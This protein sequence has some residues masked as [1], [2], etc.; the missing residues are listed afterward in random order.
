MGTYVPQ[1]DSDVFVS[2]SWAD[3][4][5]VLGIDVGWVSHIVDTLEI[6]LAQELGRD[7]IFKV[8]MDKRVRGQRHTGDILNAAKHTATMLLIFSPGYLASDWCRLER[9]CFFDSLDGN[10]HENLR[11]VFVVEKRRRR[12]IPLPPEL[13]G[14]ITYNFWYKDKNNKIRTYG[15]PTFQ[16]QQTEYYY[17]IQD[18]VDDIVDVL[19]ILKDS[20][21]K[22]G[23]SDAG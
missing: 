2:Y 9:N 7:D 21:N 20:N 6:I 3:N 19:E 12:Q 11:R 18:I 8:W 23:E 14:V 15:L 13:D 22:D 10:G 4:R 5:P 17:M 1:Y 16:P